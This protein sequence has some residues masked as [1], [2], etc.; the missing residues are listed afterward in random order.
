MEATSYL[1]MTITY[2]GVEEEQ[3]TAS[4]KNT[5]KRTQLMKMSGIH[6]GKIN[7]A[8]ML[9]LCKMMVI[10]KASYK[11]HLT[12]S[13]MQV[14]ERWENL[15]K[16]VFKI[17]L[18]VYAKMRRERLRDNTGMETFNQKQRVATARMGRTLKARAEAMSDNVKAQRDIKR[19][20]IAQEVLNLEMG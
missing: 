15:E 16:E 8:R 18:G 20:E 14:K 2:D 10:Q 3:S 11:L 17:A 4:I 1:G 19:L 5:I 9:R 12:K 7:S 6:A 13:S